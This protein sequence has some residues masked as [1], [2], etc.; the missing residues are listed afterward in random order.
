VRIVHLEDHGQDFTEFHV[1]DQGVIVDARPFQAWVWSGWKIENKIRKGG[2]LRLRKGFQGMSLK[3]RVISVV[4]GTANA[5]PKAQEP[6]PEA[7]EKQ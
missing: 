5:S 4:P 1:N 7:K 3:Y 6:T 2:M